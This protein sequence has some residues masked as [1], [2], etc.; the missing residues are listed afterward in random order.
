MKSISRPH[1]IKS[2]LPVMMAITGLSLTSAFAQIQPAARAL[3][4]SVAAK[5][6]TAKTLRL[7]ARHQLDPSLGVGSKLEKGPLEITVKR[8][9]QFYVIQSAGTETREIAYDGR[10]FC[11]IHPGLGHHALEPVKAASVEQFSDIL[12]TRF[13]FRPP[14]GELLANDLVAQLFVNVTSATVVGRERVGWT[15]CERLQWK[16]PGLTGDLWVGAKD[17]LPRRLRFTYTDQ[18][19]SPVWDIH[20][21]KW[22]LNVP[23]NEALFSKRPPADSIKVQMLKSR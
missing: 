20:L 16:Q 5:L 17:K 9:N 10:L 13:G 19:G 18:P 6:G 2:V 22:E 4:E 23:V 11:L 21:S 8:P 15:S 14:L 1:K 7:T 12:D 3:A